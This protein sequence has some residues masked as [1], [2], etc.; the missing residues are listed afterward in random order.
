MHLQDCFE[1]LGLRGGA[2]PQS[3]RAAAE[4]LAIPVHPE[5]SAA[6]ARYVVA[7]LGDVLTADRQAV[8]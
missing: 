7:C 5:L 2:Y 8:A 6:Q 1:Y 3:E 4:T